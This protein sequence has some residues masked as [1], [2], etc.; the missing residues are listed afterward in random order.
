M[1]EREC[2]VAADGRHHFY[3]KNDPSTKHLR[4]ECW[5]C[6]DPIKPVEKRTA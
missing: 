3:V 4:V 1:T 5:A 6:G 2:E